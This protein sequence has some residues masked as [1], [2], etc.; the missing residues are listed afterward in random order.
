[1]NM[2]TAVGALVV[3]TVVTSFCADY[4]ASRSLRLA[5]EAAL[6]PPRVCSA[7]QHVH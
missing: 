3:V 1:M 2:P 5:L 6:R 4:R 7:A